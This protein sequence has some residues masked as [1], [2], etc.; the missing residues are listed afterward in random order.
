MEPR[1]FAEPLPPRLFAA[2]LGAPDTFLV[3]GLGRFARGCAAIRR[4]RVGTTAGALCAELKPLYACH[5]A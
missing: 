3:V 2:L 1:G 4:P 5:Y